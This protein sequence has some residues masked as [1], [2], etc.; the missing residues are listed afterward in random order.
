[1]VQTNLPAAL[2]VV[3]TGHQANLPQEA[4]AAA[5]WQTA[6]AI[7]P[8]L[9]ARLAHAPTVPPQWPRRFPAHSKMAWHQAHCPAG[10]REAFRIRHKNWRCR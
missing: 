2:E 1:M 3:Q 9:H 6:V 10:Q 4:R 5:D 8:A 7:L